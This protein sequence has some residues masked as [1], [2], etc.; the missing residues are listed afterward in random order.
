MLLPTQADV[1]A[2]R[3]SSYRQRATFLVVGAVLI[4]ASH[5][6]DRVAAGG[7]APAALSL[8]LAWC[9]LLL[10][11]ALAL[12]RGGPLAIGVI[13]L[14]APFGSAAIFLGLILVTGRS[15]SPL[16]SFIFVLVMMLPL[17]LFDALPY[18][19]LSSGLALA[20][21]WV[22]VVQDGIGGAALWGWVHIGAAA[23]AL[24]W[25]LAV[26]FAHSL[27]IEQAATAERQAALDRLQL[28]LHE[29]QQLVG[30]LREALVRVKTLSG[31]LPICSF[32]KK[33]RNDEGYWE[34]LEG[35]VSSHSEARF[36]HSFCPQCMQ[37]QYPE[38]MED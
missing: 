26:A 18:G 38:H 32:C 14:A 25:V 8:R 16:F 15:G 13:R 37:E 11:T 12:R 1:D 20:G 9:T 31:L 6:V 33:I 2:K 30:D 36:S 10:L 21:S 22:I 24:G 4:L 28:A 29:N 34:Q 17:L 7:A 27:A 23:F 19:L 3:E 35:Y 5:V